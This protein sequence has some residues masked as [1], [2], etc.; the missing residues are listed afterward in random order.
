MSGPGRSSQTVRSG[1]R[2]LEQ[3]S[4][5]SF[6]LGCDMVVL[7]LQLKEFYKHGAQQ[8]AYIEIEL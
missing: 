8:P 6:S 7:Y 3:L 1:Q 4:V 2:G 5:F